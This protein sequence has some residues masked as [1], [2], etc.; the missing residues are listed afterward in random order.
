MA[1]PGGS[2]PELRIGEDYTNA[3]VDEA[4]KTLR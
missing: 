1:H 4:L 2:Q 3:F